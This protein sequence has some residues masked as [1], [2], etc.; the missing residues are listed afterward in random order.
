MHETA[1]PYLLGQ[2]AF[3]VDRHARALQP[4]LGASSSGV[5]T[6]ANSAVRGPPPPARPP[7]ALCLLPPARSTR[8]V[9]CRAARLA[10][11]SANARAGGQVDIALWD[12]WGQATGQPIQQL[13]GGAW[14]PACPVYATCLGGEGRRGRCWH[15]ASGTIINTYYR[16]SIDGLYGA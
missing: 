5:E 6:R 10:R 13:L 16:C 14:R 8:S 9:Q 3:A 4:M 12:A 7:L 11:A 2:P 15:Y 1:A